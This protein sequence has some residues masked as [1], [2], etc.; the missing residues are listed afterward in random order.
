MADEASYDSYGRRIEEKKTRHV[1]KYIVLTIVAGAIIVGIAMLVWHFW[2]K[3]KRRPNMN[4]TPSHTT[5][6]PNPHVVEMGHP[7]PAP[8]TAP[9]AAPRPA[10]L[11][12]SKLWTPDELA[13]L[14]VLDTDSMSRLFVETIDQT[15]LEIRG[16]HG[17]VQMLAMPGDDPACPCKATSASI[18]VMIYQD[19]CPTCRASAPLFAAAAKLVADYHQSNPSTPILKFAVIDYADVPI[20]VT[21]HLPKE[22]PSFLLYDAADD[23]VQRVNI[24][25][26]AV[27]TEQIFGYYNHLTEK[28][29]AM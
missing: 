15:S 6:A 2:A 25:D 10:L 26:L 20:Y 11:K 5:P 23:L 27:L 17:H 14:E 7:K 22:T 24:S 4:P 9:I 16:K 21:N 12:A 1:V 28:T 3:K 13:Y 18:I 8:N 19:Q 29:S